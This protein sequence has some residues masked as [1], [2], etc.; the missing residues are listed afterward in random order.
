MRHIAFRTAV[1][2]AA[3]S[4][5]FAASANAATHT[6][7][8]T[9]K[10]D[11]AGGCHKKCSLREAVMAADHDG[12]KST[13]IIPAGTYGLTIK[14]TSAGTPTDNPAVGDLDIDAKAFI[15]IKGAGAS[16]TILDANHID[17]MFAIHQGASLTLS[18]ATVENGDDNSDYPSAYSISG[19]AQ[20]GDGGAFFN[21]GSLSITK[22]ILKGNSAYNYGGTIYSYIHAASTDVTDSTVVMNTA[23]YPGALLYALH[24]NVGLTGDTIEYN[25]GS[26]AGGTVWGEGVGA[27]TVAHTKLDYNTG[28]GAGS[29]L[30]LDGAGRVS[31]TH[32]TF[33]SNSSEGDGGA[34]YLQLTGVI[35]IAHSTF[36]H[37]LSDSDGGAVAIYSSK[38]ASVTD[39]NFTDDSGGDDDGG[40]AIYLGDTDPMT[41]SGSSFVGNTT[42]GD[43]GAIGA[44]DTT[45]KVRQSKF[46]NNVG[47]DG[48]A[49]SADGSNLTVQLSQFPD[50]EAI[51]SGGALY[52]D[53]S[54]KTAPQSITSS[55]F[56]G[57][58]AADA[59]GGAIDDDYGDL[60]LTA[61]TFSH[62]NSTS[63]G[64]ALYYD[65]GDG[66][67]LVNDTFDGND[68]GDGGALYLDESAVVGTVVLRN[69]TIARNNA[70]E[71]G[72][73]QAPYHANTIINTIIADNVGELGRGAST[74]NGD[75][76]YVFDWNNTLDNY[77][78][79]TDHGNN[80]DSD[81]SCIA[82]P[83]GKPAHGDKTANPRLGPLKNNGGPVPTDALLSGSPAIGAADK[84]DCPT[85]DA[86]GDKR[87]NK[88]DIGAYQTEPKKHKKKRKK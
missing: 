26:G 42:A 19:A 24:G 55:V 48:G 13:I 21:D 83:G 30:Y 52:I 64:G 46:I 14:A 2:A 62:N 58:L 28:D 75:C 35:S 66:M 27:V 5:L 7:K 72:G 53:G 50:D 32:S 9:T 87:N 60:E 88:C 40:G 34:V 29:A 12:G 44:D 25:Y 86:R 73:I 81:H 79:T 8:V 54:Y 51:D 85:R 10:P 84:A 57:D 17:R 78:G 38:A 76:D 65:S 45:T 15:T 82:H 36:S 41:V 63:D 6:F 18:G 77:T 74:G 20:T 71:G 69:D 39:S 23:D 33:S 3:S 80:L 68:A 37:N 1:L 61:S 47:D 11:A 16:K 31:I 67:S 22:S 70:F 49:I 4:L 43:G 59:D 56:T